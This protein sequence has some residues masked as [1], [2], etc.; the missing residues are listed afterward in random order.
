MSENQEKKVL[1]E[2]VISVLR[3]VY[4]PEIPV[5]LYELGLIYETIVDPNKNV[6]IK[7][8]LTTP[9]CPVAGS[10]PIEVEQ[11]LKKIEGIGDVTVEIVWDPPWNMNMMSDEARFELGFL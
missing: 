9:A 1:E 10:L 4:D 5:N 11:K 2:K 6:L 7:M 8:T 3:T